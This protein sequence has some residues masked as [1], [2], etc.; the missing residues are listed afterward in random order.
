[1]PAGLTPRGAFRT[2]LR[3]MVQGVAPSDLIPG[4]AGAGGIVELDIDAALLLVEEQEMIVLAPLR[5]LHNEGVDMMTALQAA[6]LMVDQ[7]GPESTGM[8]QGRGELEYDTGAA[9]AFP[10]FPRR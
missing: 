1:M 5:I 2:R 3:A 9:S 4:R 10:V 7:R 8:Q 6:L